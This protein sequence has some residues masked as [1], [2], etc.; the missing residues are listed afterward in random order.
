MHTTDILTITMN[1]ALDVSTST[2]KVRDTH[3][4][5]CAAAQFHPGGGGINVARVLHRLGSNCLALYPSG[6]A[7]GQRLGQLLEQEQV[8]HRGLPIAGETRESFS[9]HET[10]SGK[11]FRFVLPGPSLSAPEWQACLD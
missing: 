6:G 5:R 1:P 9:V 8:R 4:L 7:T 10:S 11:D 3:K 2:D